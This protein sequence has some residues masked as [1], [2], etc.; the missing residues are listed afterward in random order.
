MQ[1]DYF[2]KA[3]GLYKSYSN[4]LGSSRSEVLKGLDLIVPQGEKVAVMGPSGSGKTTL[5]NLIGTLDEPDSGEIWIDGT[6]VSGIKREE[7]LELRNGKLGF[8]FQQHHL[9]PQCTMLENILLPALPNRNTSE[10]ALH[11]ARELMDFMGIEKLGNNKPGE[12]SG[13]ECQRAAVARSL[14]NSPGLLLADEPTGSLDSENAGRL[15]EL[16]VRINDQMD[17]TMLIAT[18]SAD[19][20]GKMDR[21]CVIKEG[22][23]TE[24]SKQSN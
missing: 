23:L 17:V 3:K 12:L 5:L 18:H 9:L 11:R 4:T 19:I 13:G 21:V 24:K 8:V 10:K 20:A 1:A 15:M 16:L 7:L 6:L 22:L 2:I 14:I